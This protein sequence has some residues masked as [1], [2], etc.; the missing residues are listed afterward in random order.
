MLPGDRD[1]V[2]SR[3]SLL[4]ATALAGATPVVVAG[5]PAR[6][7]ETVPRVPVTPVWSEDL[8]RSYG[9]GFLPVNSSPAYGYVEDWMQQVADLGVAYIRGRYLPKA[10]Q[11]ARI[12][13]GCRALGVKWLMSVI[14]ENWSMTEEQLNAVL[15]HIRDNAADVCLGIEGMN[16]PNHNRD[17]SPLRIDWAQAAVAYQRVIKTFLSSTPTMAGAVSVGPSLQMGADDPSPDFFAMADAGL[18]PY[19]D[20]AGLHSY[21]AGWGPAMYVETRLGYVRDAWGAVPTWVTET[22]YNTASGAPFVEEGPK[23]VPEDIAATYGPRSV[24]EYYRRGCKAARFQ[25][26]DRVN[27]ANDMPVANY[28]IIENTGDHPS[29]WT[30]KLEFTV[31]QKFLTSLRDT[32]VESYA[33]P[34]VS[35]GVQGPRN[36]RWTAVGKS[37]GSCR[38]LMYRGAPVW[39]PDTRTRRT[40]KAADVTVVDSLGTRVIKVGAQLVRVRVY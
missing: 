20:H 39:N 37:D 24:L 30:R 8:R 7:A 5:V 11:T 40:V 2:V 18:P 15:G 35:V 14:P 38:L 23:P 12:V 3:R 21:P 34:A 36:L 31:M 25:L 22:G 10:A 32:A 13:E 29:T 6:A 16:E 17:G 28:G 19:I 9:I 1:P 33:P 27:P 4:A 26:L